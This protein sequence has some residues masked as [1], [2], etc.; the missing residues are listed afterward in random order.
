MDDLI[1][2]ESVLEQ[3]KR[4][5]YWFTRDGYCA[6]TYDDIETAINNMPAVEA[7]SVSWLETV[8][9]DADEAGDLEMRDAIT[10]LIDEWHR[11][12]KG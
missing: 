8:R 3:I 5:P 4:M 11:R 1:S 7:I 10:N 12:N 6:L 2:R 9:N